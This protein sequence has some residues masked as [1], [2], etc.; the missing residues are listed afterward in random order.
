MKLVRMLIYLYKRACTPLKTSVRLI[1]LSIKPHNPLN[2]PFLGICMPLKSPYL[3]I[4]LSR[5]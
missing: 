4:E 5:I 3:C 2:Y 1:F